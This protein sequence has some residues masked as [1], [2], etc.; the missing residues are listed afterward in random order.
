MRE[1]RSVEPVLCTKALAALLDV[2]QGQLPEGLKA[3]PDDVI[4]TFAVKFVHFRLATRPGNLENL[5]FSGDFKQ[6]GNVIH[7]FLSQ[8]KF[9][10]I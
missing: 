5:E 10:T 2:L 1:S 7:F 3:E 6:P 9:E 4:G 8:G